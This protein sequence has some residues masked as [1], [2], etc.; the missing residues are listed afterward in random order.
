MAG[1]AEKPAGIIRNPEPQKTKGNTKVAISDA[2]TPPCG[3]S[4]LLL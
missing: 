3:S 1:V 4:I 2:P